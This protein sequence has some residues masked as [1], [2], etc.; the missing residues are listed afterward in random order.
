MKLFLVH[1]M[2]FVGSIPYGR[3]KGVGSCLL[4]PCGAVD[5]YTNCAF[6]WDSSL[7]FI[8]SFAPNLTA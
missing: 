3:I 2:L 8:P 7:N 1:T 4:C 6:N 5:G